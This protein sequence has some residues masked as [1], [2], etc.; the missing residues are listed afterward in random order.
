MPFSASIDLLTNAVD[1]PAILL[2]HLTAAGSGID[3]QEGVPDLPVHHSELAIRQTNA[4][5]GREEH[6]CGEPELQYF[7]GRT[8]S[9]F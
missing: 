4:G 1:K 5:V 9:D 8:P 2:P 6:F 7:R 3:F